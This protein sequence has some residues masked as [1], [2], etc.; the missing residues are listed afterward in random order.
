VAPANY[1]RKFRSVIATYDFDAPA[2]QQVARS[3]SMT[4]AGQP[5]RILQ[6]PPRKNTFV[7]DY[8]FDQNVYFSANCIVRGSL[9]VWF[10][11]PRPA[12]LPG[13]G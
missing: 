8:Q 7:V 6:I 9:V 1:E 4:E 13:V 10:K 11:A 5:N 3:R 2:A 12:V